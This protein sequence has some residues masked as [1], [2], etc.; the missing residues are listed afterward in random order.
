MENIETDIQILLKKKTSFEILR[1][2]G[3]Q[4]KSGE[5]RVLLL[6]L[7]EKE[8][9][10]PRVYDLLL[11]RNTE[12]TELMTVP[13]KRS[14]VYNI[15]TGTKPYALGTTSKPCRSLVFTLDTVAKIGFCI[16]T[17]MYII[18]N[19]RISLKRISNS[20]VNNH[21]TVI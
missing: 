16:F 15:I 21:R 7:R 11:S 20:L 14:S 9:K 1:F 10:K 5:R 8:Y 2:H 17:Q 18:I 13:W 4:R 6:S 19:W 12:A 3:K